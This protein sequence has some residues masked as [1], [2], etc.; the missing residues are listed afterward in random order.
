MVQHDRQHVVQLRQIVEDAVAD[1][2]VL[3]DVLV[4][5]VGELARLA[6]HVVVDADLADV[7]QQ[8]RQ[9]DAC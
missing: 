5:V 7:V 4:F 2:D 1:L 8:A 9:V 3:L 6:E